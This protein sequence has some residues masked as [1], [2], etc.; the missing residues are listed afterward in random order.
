MLNVLL[1]P[2]LFLTVILLSACSGLKPF[3]AK[4]LWEYDAKS[5]V[6]GEYEIT[7]P[8][9]L[10]FRHIRDVPLSQ[11]PTTFGFSAKDISAVLD[12]SRAAREYVNNHCN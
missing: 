3:P 2:L 1:L 12:W 5:K 10:R 4:T 6:C 7:D 11:C 8:E 9:A